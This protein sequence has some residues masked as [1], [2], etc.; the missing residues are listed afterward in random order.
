MMKKQVTYRNDLLKRLKNTDYALAYLNDCA[1]DKDP[2]V[3]IDAI[4]DVSEAHSGIRRF[5][6]KAR[7]TRKHFLSMLKKWN[8][9]LTSLQELTHAFGWRIALVPDDKKYRKAA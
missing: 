4:N 2:G 7:L 6:K 3:L 1:E 9:P 5:A 8:P